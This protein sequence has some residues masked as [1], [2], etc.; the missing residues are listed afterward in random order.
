MIYKNIKVE[1]PSKTVRYSNNGIYYEVSRTYKKDKKYN[2]PNR[3]CIGKAI[4][5]KY[6]YPNENYET[7]FPNESLLK[8]PPLLSDTLSIGFTSVV[9]KL[10][11]DLQID[12]ILKD[13]YSDDEYDLIRDLIVYMISYSTTVI[14]HF[15]SASRRFDILSNTIRSD[16][17]ISTFFKEVIT[18][19]KIEQFLN[20]WNLLDRKKDVLYIS[21]DSTNMN[22]NAVGI[23][24]AE[25]GHPKVD[26]E[27]PQVNLSYV[28]N[29]S[30]CLP[31]F[32]ELYPGSNI[33]NSQLKHMVDRLSEY[34]YKNIGV[35]LDRGYYSRY[36]INYLR[37]KGYDFLL[38]V[39]TNS[40]IIEKHIQEKQYS[41]NKEKYY[42]EAHDVFG[43]TIEDKIFENDKVKSFIHIYYDSSRSMDEAKLLYRNVS[44]EAKQLDEHILKHHKKDDLKSEYKHFKLQADKEGYLVSYTKNDDL[45]EAE[46]RS[47]GFFSIITSSKMSASDA[48]D[49]YRD[50]DSVEKLF[51][52][53]K[54]ELDYKKFRV[55]TGRS[56]AGKTFITF[57]AT[58]IR[59]RIYYNSKP[60]RK[61]D[62]KQYTTNAI[63][64][65]LSN[66][67][68]TKN[69][70]DIYTRRYSLTA[71]QKNILSKFNISEKDIILTT[72]SINNRLSS[73]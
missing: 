35:I 43:T 1:I 55:N 62:R 16:S 51:E 22:T 8:E 68:I 72:N 53:L 20:D 70:K 52:S 64:N 2:T 69:A 37:D 11:D 18:D 42:I 12:L 47:L 27:L 29:K 36:N 44:N 26:E 7:Y 9:D 63:I 58:I 33:D 38:M 67:E 46:A 56:L 5:E 13:Y 30:D 23:E 48:L 14:Q 4:D 31:L 65:E 17:Y 59:S 60:L 24:L 15:P 19:K 40:E 61:N 32:Y 73:K 10:I 54:S 45:I 6:M 41:I 3:I 57:L 50:R 21:Y 66:I 39:K 71:K 25:Y 28:I 34:G 49:A